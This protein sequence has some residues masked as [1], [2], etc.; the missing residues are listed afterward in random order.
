M[1]SFELK[2]FPIQ[3]S[4]S[5]VVSPLSSTSDMLLQQC[6]VET[7][8]PKIWGMWPMLSLQIRGYGFDQEVVGWSGF[9][10][11]QGVQKGLVEFSL[12]MQSVVLCVYVLVSVSLCVCVFTRVLRLTQ[13]VATY[14]SRG[15]Y[16]NVLHGESCQLGYLKCSNVIEVLAVPCCFNL[17]SDVH[18]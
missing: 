1:L 18:T 8:T 15:D 14:H 4:F 2:L 13:D 12:E 9:D 16:C 6:W 7:P 5:I 3:P 10:S 17:M 11:S